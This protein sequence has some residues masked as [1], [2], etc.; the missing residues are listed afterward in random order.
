[1]FKKELDS[2]VRELALERLDAVP[3]NTL[4]K[5]QRKEI[6]RKW[7][8]YKTISQ[9]N[10]ENSSFYSTLFSQVENKRHDFYDVYY[11]AKHSPYRK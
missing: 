6:V 1:M 2:L 7:R 5:L 11:M 8:T 4:G 10:A 3:K 9:E